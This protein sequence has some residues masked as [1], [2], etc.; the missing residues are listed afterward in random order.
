M[1]IT[2]LSAD[3]S[4]DSKSRTD[5][6]FSSAA[7]DWRTYSPERS[8]FYPS[9]VVPFKIAAKIEGTIFLNIRLKK[10][11]EKNSIRLRFR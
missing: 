7:F 9:Q 2:N 4:F 5:S 10:N 11:Y 8:F 3:I 1:S 6:D